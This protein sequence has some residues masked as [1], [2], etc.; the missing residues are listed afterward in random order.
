MDLDQNVGESLLIDLSLSGFW[1]LQF[2]AVRLENVVDAT[3]LMDLR[4]FVSYT[5]G[6]DCGDPGRNSDNGRLC[7]GD[8]ELSFNL[9]SVELLDRR[10]ALDFGTR[11]LSAFS[12]LVGNAPAAVPEPNAVLLLLGLLQ[13]CGSAGGARRPRL[14]GS[15][16]VSEKYPSAAPC[17]HGE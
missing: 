8:G 1:D 16:A 6:F 17:R 14:A 5:I 3:F 12:I 10:F 2:K 13:A 9:A 4:P 7:G 11:D 15:G